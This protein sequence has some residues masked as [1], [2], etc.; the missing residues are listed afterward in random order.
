[1]PAYF[2][3]LIPP[4]PT[5]MIDMSEDEKEIMMNHVGYWNKLLEDNIAI[6]FGPVLDSKGAYGV[7]VV[8]VETEEQLLKVM[9]DDPANGLNKFEFYPMR[10]VHK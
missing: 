3:K 7:G 9:G 6:V 10:A 2:L 4:Q 8:N 1:M 5:F